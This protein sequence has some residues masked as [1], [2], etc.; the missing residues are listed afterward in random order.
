VSWDPDHRCRGKGKVHYD[1]EDEEMH[2]DATIGAYLE[3]SDEA[4]DSYASDG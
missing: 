2:E 4:S 3:Q 1:S